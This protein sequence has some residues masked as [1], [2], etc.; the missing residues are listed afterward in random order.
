MDSVSTGNS[1]PRHC[2][3]VWVSHTD[4]GVLRV[5]QPVPDR[6]L[7]VYTVD[8]PV[9]IPANRVVVAATTPALESENLKILLNRLLPTAPVPLPPP[10]RYT[11]ICN[12]WC[13][14]YFWECR[15]RRQHRHLRPGSREWKLCCNACSR[16]AGLGRVGT[17]D[18]ACRDWSTMVCF[19]VANWAWCGQVPGTR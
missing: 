16:G 8:E 11:Q 17:T 9:G 14:A 18:P 3:R 6:A 15:Q 4:T 1:Y 5:V 10:S 12:C 2:C 13:S 7:P 19:R